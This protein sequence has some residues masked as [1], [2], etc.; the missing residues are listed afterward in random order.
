[1]WNPFDFTNKKYL[2]TGASSGIGAATAISLSLQGAKVCL[3]A[4]NEERLEETRSKMTGD[5]HI[6]IT[7]DLS[8]E[9]D[10]KQLFSDAVSDGKK[11]DGL[12]YCAGIAKILPSTLLNK[13]NMDESMTTNLYSFAEMVSVFSKKKF[14]EEYSS[15]VGVSSICVKY[16]Q[17]CQGIYAATKAGMNAM[18]TSLAIELAKKNIRI[19]TVMPSVTQTRM[20]EEAWRDR[21]EEEIRRQM[22]AQ[23]LGISDPK[24][25][26]DVIMFLLSDASSVITGRAIS[27]DAGTLDFL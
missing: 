2:V 17:Q 24:Q 4:R 21:S 19:N 3:V 5:G 13:K 9:F 8:R 1:M 10:A 12:V 23:V 27:S 26:A 6:I 15:I 7:A 20:M 11:L 16:P 14:R 25:I 18:V 22:N